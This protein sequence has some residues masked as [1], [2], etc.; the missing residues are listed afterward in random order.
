MD[1]DEEQLDFKFRFGSF[2][3]WRSTDFIKTQSC[4][5]IYN[6]VEPDEDGTRIGTDDDS[7]P[8]DSVHSNG[9]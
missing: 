6:V 3:S 8:A 5:D 4:V 7:S 1:S 9:L 2:G